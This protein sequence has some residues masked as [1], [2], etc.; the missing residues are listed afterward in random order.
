MYGNARLRL[1]GWVAHPAFLLGFDA[2]SLFLELLKERL[3]S[4]ILYLR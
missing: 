2:P 3:C 4:L 1:V